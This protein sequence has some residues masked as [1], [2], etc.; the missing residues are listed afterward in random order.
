MR[1]GLLIGLLVLVLGGTATAA[2]GISAGEGQLNAENYS[3]AYLLLRQEAADGNARSQFLLGVMS[4]NGLGPIALDP[5]EA[6][7]W[8]RIAAERGSV[9]AQFR[10][11]SAH[12][13]GRGVAKDKSEAVHWLERAAEQGFTPA[14]RSLAELYGSGKVAADDPG[15]AEKLIARAAQLG[16]AEAQFTYAG[17]LETGHGMTPDP[18]AALTWYRRAADQGHVPAQLQLGRSLAGP[19]AADEQALE[20]LMWLGVALRATESKAKD[21]RGKDTK[22]KDEA[23]AIRTQVA[24]IRKEL[25]ARLPPYQIAD[26]EGRARA[27]KPEPAATDQR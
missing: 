15:A 5:R 4:D 9:E 22:A 14:M 12:F 26:A 16:D 17:W 13:V 24:A 10:L 6:A 23:V 27:W 7:R 11:A 8:Y 2:T 21:A 20:G 1:R 3:G 19:S 18:S 25:S